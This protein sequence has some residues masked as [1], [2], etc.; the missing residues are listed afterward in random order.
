M[1]VIVIQLLHFEAL[2]EQQ[3]QVVFVPLLGRQILQ[4]DHGVLERHLFDVL[5]EVQKQGSAH[6]AVELGEAL[7]LGEVGVPQADCLINIEFSSQVAADPP[8]GE[9]HKVDV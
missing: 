5:R 8:V 9:I 6:V 1:P 7:I 2:G 3:I 4:V